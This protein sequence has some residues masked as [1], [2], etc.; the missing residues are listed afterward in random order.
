MRRYAY[1]LI[2]LSFAL[3]LVLAS[4]AGAQATNTVAVQVA[5]HTMLLS[6]SQ[7]D[8]VTVH[9]EIAYGLVDTSTLT[10]NGVVVAWTKADSRGE[11]VAKFREADVKAVLSSPE[12]TLTLR[13]M[14]VAGGEFS[15]EDTV[16]VRD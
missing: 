10:L 5:P 1:G 4:L 15:G 14:T 9:A 7:A 11:L 6:S 12:T 13:G 16:K 2:M 8:F 3:G